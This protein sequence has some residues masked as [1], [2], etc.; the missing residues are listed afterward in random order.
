[1]TYALDTNIIIRYLRDNELVKQNIREAILEKQEL[2]IPRAVDYEMCRGFR[3]TP[4]PKKSKNYN[5]F[6]YNGY[7]DVVEVCPRTWQKAEEVYAELYS[8]G[9]TVGEIDILIAAF[10]LINDYTLVTNNTKDFENISSLR[11]VDWTK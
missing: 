7:C 4:A 10:C 1:M 9:F 5:D 11:L 8:K 3:C 6:A 2:I